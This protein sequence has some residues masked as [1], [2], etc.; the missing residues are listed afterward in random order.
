M[1]PLRLFPRLQKDEELPK[2]QIYFSWIPV[3]SDVVDLM[4]L[5]GFEFARRRE[6]FEEMVFSKMAAIKGGLISKVHFFFFFHR[7]IVM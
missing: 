5:K 1:V 3:Y 6:V 4:S 2:F 7:Q